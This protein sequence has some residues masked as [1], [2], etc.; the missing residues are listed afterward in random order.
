M[1]IGKCLS[2]VRSA[3]LLGALQEQ[4]DAL[5]TW[6]KRFVASLVLWRGG[7]TLRQSEALKRV[8]IRHNP[9]VYPP[10]LDDE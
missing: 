8:W 5:S 6:E 9:G 2:R 4:Y 10:W 7:P 3:E 1:A